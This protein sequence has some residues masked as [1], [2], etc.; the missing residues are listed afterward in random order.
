M[1]TNTLAMHLM[2]LQGLE[3]EKGEPYLDG[4]DLLRR[5]SFPHSGL[6]RCLHLL[7]L[8]RAFSL[9]Q[10]LPWLK[11]PVCCERLWVRLKQPLRLLLFLSRKGAWL[12]S[13][14]IPWQ[15]LKS[16]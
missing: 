4:S 7:I 3:I 14:Q 15:I 5:G 8:C 9:R 1:C 16:A 10:A 11:G 13:K 6:W 2:T 12:T